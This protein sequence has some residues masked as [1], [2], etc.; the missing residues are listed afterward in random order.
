MR[1]AAL[2]RAS[3]ETLRTKNYLRS[4]SAIAAVLAIPNAST[5][6]TRQTAKAI[7]PIAYLRCYLESYLVEQREASARLRAPAKPFNLLRKVVDALGLEPR[8]R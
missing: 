7:K 6:R 3:V 2:A 1:Q 5:S 4:S 8:T